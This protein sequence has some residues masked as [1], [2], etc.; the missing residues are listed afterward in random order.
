MPKTP[1][2][3]ECDARTYG[4]HPLQFSRISCP[5]PCRRQKENKSKTQKERLDFQ[6]TKGL[7][8]V[9][10]VDRSCGSL[11]WGSLGLGSLCRR[12]NITNPYGS[13]TSVASGATYTLSRQSSHSLALSASVLLLGVAEFLPLLECTVGAKRTCLS[14]A[15][16]GLRS[17]LV[18]VVF[19][20]LSENCI[21]RKVRFIRI[22]SPAGTAW[23]HRCCVSPPI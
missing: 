23:S 1:A 3:K 20:L 5:C 9:D 22:P 12:A 18:S 14:L 4:A 17:G 8:A 6:L 15:P 19:R 21:T 2:E 13:G 11:G 10:L 7:R 16:S